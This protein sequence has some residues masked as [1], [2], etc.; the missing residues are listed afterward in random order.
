MHL[1]Y[2]ICTARNRKG[3]ALTDHMPLHTLVQGLYERY[4]DKYGQGEELVVL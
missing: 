4:K 3:P 2:G 1:P